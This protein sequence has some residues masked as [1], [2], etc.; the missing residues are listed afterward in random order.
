MLFPSD[1]QVGNC[2]T[3]QIIVIL[4]AYYPGIIVI[5]YRFVKVC[6]TVTSIRT[7][8]YKIRTY[9]TIWYYTKYVKNITE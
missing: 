1:I 6:H 8:T 9:K 4:C 2:N 5:I 7:Y 3:V